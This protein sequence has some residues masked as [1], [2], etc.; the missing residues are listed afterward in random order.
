MVTRI[1]N[2]HIRFT[3]CFR[4]KATDLMANALQHTSFHADRNA[5]MLWE[6]LVLIAVLHKKNEVDNYYK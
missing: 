2:G 1:V 6:K 3:F 4:V 5:A